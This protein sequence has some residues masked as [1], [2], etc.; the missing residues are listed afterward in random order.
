MVGRLHEW[1]LLAL[2][3]LHSRYRARSLI[4]SLRTVGIL[5]AQWPARKTVIGQREWKSLIGQSLWGFRP[6]EVLLAGRELREW[7]GGSGA[8][9]IKPD[10]V[11]CIQRP[12]C[13]CNTKKIQNQQILSSCK[14]A[15]QENGLGRYL[16]R[17]GGVALFPFV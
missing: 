6:G 2:W 5:A 8:I 4:R 1:T 12:P 13:N 9:A 3:L 11:V 10:V 15:R 16:T 17:K 7:S 14:K